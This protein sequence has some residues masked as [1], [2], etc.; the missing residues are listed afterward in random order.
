MTR[1]TA[2]LTFDADPALND[3]T[4]W[5]WEEIAVGALGSAA[6]LQDVRV[7]EVAEAAGIERGTRPTLTAGALADFL[8]QFPAD[9]PVVIALPDHLVNQE[10]LDV[11][12]WMNVAHAERDADHPDEQVAVLLFAEA[13]FDTRQW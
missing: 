10:R 1:Y 8:R 5:G 6:T 13:D 9:H 7:A 12:E 11:D 2:T 3:P 4:A